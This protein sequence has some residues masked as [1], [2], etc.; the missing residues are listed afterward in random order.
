[1]EEM[2]NKSETIDNHKNVRT[3]DPRRKKCVAPGIVWNT[4]KER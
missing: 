1:M 3:T 4:D 2:D